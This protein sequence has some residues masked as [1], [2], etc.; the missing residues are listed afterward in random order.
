MIEHALEA[1]VELRAWR[2]H[3]G[4]AAFVEVLEPEE[5]DAFHGS[6]SRPL[7]LRLRTLLEP[8]SHNVCCAGRAGNLASEP[9]ETHLLFLAQHFQLVV[10]IGI[11]FGLDRNA[12]ALRAFDFD[13]ASKCEAASSGHQLP[14]ELVEMGSPL[15]F[16]FVVVRIVRGRRRTSFLGTCARASGSAFYAAKQEQRLER[17]ITY[18]KD[19]AH[20]TRPPPLPS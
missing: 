6:R 9:I 1:G 12:R 19:G 8:I 17:F 11:R 2:D 14:A 16:L 15:Q 10:F 18:P 13:V 3:E 7:E 20:A 4:S 5:V